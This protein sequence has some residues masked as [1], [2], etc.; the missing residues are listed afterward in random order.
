MNKRSQTK[1]K[2]TMMEQS[3]YIGAA[4]KMDPMPELRRASITQVQPSG[5]MENQHGHWLYSDGETGI[6]KEAMVLD[7]CDE[8]RT[9]EEGV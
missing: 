8:H 5:G 4:T 7:R 2:A 9:F 6:E 3:Q 1:A